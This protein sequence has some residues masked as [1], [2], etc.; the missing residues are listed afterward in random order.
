MLSKLKQ[1][2]ADQTAQNGG[3]PRK[4][5]LMDTLFRDAHQCLWATRMKTEDMLPIAGLMDEAGFQVLEVMGLVQYDAAVRFLNQNPL[6]RLKLLGERITKTPMRSVVRGNLLGGFAPVHDDITELFIERQVANGASELILFDC[7]HDWN[8]VR[9]GMKKARSLGATVVGAVIYNQAPGYTDDY[10]ATISRQACDDLNVD[11]LQ[12]V[13]PGG[14]LTLERVRTLVPAIKAAITDNVVL[15]LNTHCLSGLGPLVAIEAAVLGV[16][17]IYTAPEPLA[18]GNAAPGSQNMVRNLRELGFEVDID[19]Q[20]LEKVDDYLWDLAKREG[21]P[22]GLPGEFN[23][24]LYV[25]QMAGG[26]LSNVENQMKEAGIHHRLPEVIEEIG[27]VRLELGSPVMGTPYPAIIA[28]QAV[29]NVV[30]GERYK[31][32][33]AEVKKYVCGYYGALRI[34]VDPE[35]VDRVMENGPRSVAET[36]QPLDPIVPALRARYPQAD[37]DELLMRY[38]AGDE[39]YEGL[40]PTLVP[41]EFSA[42]TPLVKLVE[43][44]SKRA[45]KSWI[46]VSGVNFAVSVGPQGQ[47]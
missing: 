13:D 36:P 14:T 4:I 16:E 47:G 2:V 34:P 33:P 25:T 30:Q 7:L 35:V 27:R 28:A 44:L 11:K 5:E 6:T 17:T 3:K 15:E 37:D 40:N 32:V 21:Q 12:I 20:K 41:D 18:Q 42:D 19:L 29:M 45:N 8:V 38:M 43:R 24:T 31:V 22:V 39:R 1:Q 23:E 9:P 46:H 10:Y 26:A